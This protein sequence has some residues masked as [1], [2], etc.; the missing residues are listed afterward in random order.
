MPF[1]VHIIKLNEIRR[2]ILTLTLAGKENLNVGTHK[3]FNKLLFKEKSVF[4]TKTWNKHK[5]EPQ[6]YALDYGQ[7]MIHHKQLYY[8]VV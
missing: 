3:H 5:K 1:I 2:F 8:R 4:I 7:A 6:K